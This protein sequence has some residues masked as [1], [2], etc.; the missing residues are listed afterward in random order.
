MPS[1]SCFQAG[2]LRT[3][4]PGRKETIWN[5]FQTMSTVWCGVRCPHV[6]GTTCPQLQ[7][8]QQRPPWIAKPFF[9]YVT[10]SNY[11]YIHHKSKHDS[12][13][14]T[15]NL[16][17]LV[18]CWLTMNI[19]VSCWLLDWTKMCFFSW[20]SSAGYTPPFSCWLHPPFSHRFCRRISGVTDGSRAAAGKAL[21]FLLPRLFFQLWM[22]IVCKFW[23]VCIYI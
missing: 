2:N 1:A 7:N 15:K 11:R 6:L 9:A 5:I 23:M 20:T 21:L 12:K 10:S 14:L 16:S 18:N 13:S 22:N 17:K 19:G 8:L 3:T 4:L